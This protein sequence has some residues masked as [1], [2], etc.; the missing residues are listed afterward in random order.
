MKKYDEQILD[1]STWITSTPTQIAAGLPFYVT[2]T[3]HF[4]AYT[5]YR[6]SRQSHDSFLLLYTISGEGSLTTDGTTLP[7]FPNHAVLFDCHN[8][9]SYQCE[10]KNWEFLWAHINGNSVR[11]LFE[12][13]YDGKLCTIDMEKEP[14]FSQLFSGLASKLQTNS[15]TASVEISS[16][17]HMLFCSILKQH[18]EKGEIQKDE[19]KEAMSQVLD[20]IKTHYAENIA[21]EDLMENI[22]FSKYHFIRLFRRV[23]GTTPY[24]YL[25]NYRINESKTLLRSTDKTVSEIASDCGFLD[26]S[27]FITQ[28]KR[29]AGQTP[30][31]YRRDFKV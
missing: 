11:P 9:H 5:G 12:L 14:S 10:T 28:F 31:Q 21:L 17:V 7:L 3:G 6:V 16:Q 18:M 15:I 24:N 2:E 27:N 20:Y 1:N 30:L 25:T 13:L 19:H 8:P 26:T 4:Q 23:M 29:H 22:H